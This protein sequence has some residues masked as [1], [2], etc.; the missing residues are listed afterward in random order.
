MALL[1]V[2]F[3]PPWDSASLRM[4]TESNKLSTNNRIKVGNILKKKMELAL[5]RATP[6]LRW[7]KETARR[8]ERA[9]RVRRANIPTRTSIPT[10]AS[11][12]KMAKMERT[13]TTTRATTQKTRHPPAT[14]E[15]LLEVRILSRRT[16]S[17]R[18]LL[19]RSRYSLQEEYSLNHP[20]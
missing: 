2:E 18:T 16:L 11:T 6:V 4:K 5:S 14:R 17:R 10:R 1:L 8:A 7:G 12:P 15:T 3:K 13:H 19:S 20:A 9:R